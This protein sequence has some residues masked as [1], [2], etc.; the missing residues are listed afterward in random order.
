MYQAFKGGELARH[1]KEAPKTEQGAAREGFAGADR[2]FPRAE[3]GHTAEVGKQPI[4]LDNPYIRLDV[5]AGSGNTLEDF[6]RNAKP[7]RFPA[8][9]R[10]GAAINESGSLP[11]HLSPA[12]FPDKSPG[13]ILINESGSLPPSFE[14]D[15]PAISRGGAAI[16]ESAGLPPQHRPMPGVFEPFG[17]GLELDPIVARI[18]ELTGQ[19]PL[20]QVLKENV[21][22]PTNELNQL[23]EK[24][25][26]S[27]ADVQKLENIVRV[28]GDREMRERLQEIKR[29]PVTE[30]VEA[31]K[32]EVEKVR[33]ALIKNQASVWP[34]S[35][36]AELSQRV[37]AL[38]MGLGMEVDRLEPKPEP[39]T[40]SGSIL[41]EDRSNLK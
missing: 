12:I 35:R 17:P 32:A 36:I 41:L 29:L 34:N 5:P 3:P 37:D 10:G 6:L 21:K 1:V 38:L 8:I 40:W 18:R 11:P 22:A 4:K 2:E 28:C 30:Q 13:G 25:D 14:R 7:D 24:K 15:V 26:L 23:L 16:N 27:V 9:S 33:D 20:D 31:L 19:R 39:K